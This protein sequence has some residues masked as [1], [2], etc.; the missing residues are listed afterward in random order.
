MLNLVELTQLLDALTGHPRVVLGRGLPLSVN[1]ISW[2]VPV[3]ATL[4]TS[5]EIRLNLPPNLNAPT[6]IAGESL[7]AFRGDS[8]EPV[9][10]PKPWRELFRGPMKL[11]R[12]RVPPKALALR[13]LRQY[14]PG[15]LPRGH[16]RLLPLNS[17]A[18]NCSN[19]LN[20][21]TR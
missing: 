4:E 21:S 6:L 13:P 7:W 8:L 18:W 3:A 10:L 14:F 12:Q 16:L 11:D 19:A 15:A 5:G 9:G 1:A 17:Y 20:V 2:R